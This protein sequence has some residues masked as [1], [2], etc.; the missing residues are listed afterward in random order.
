M[1]GGRIR[2]QNKSERERERVRR[3]GVS[4]QEGYSKCKTPKVR[5][6]DVSTIGEMLAKYEE[7]A[8]SPP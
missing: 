2:E 4:L 3:G 8:G 6:S 5:P 7:A 1:G